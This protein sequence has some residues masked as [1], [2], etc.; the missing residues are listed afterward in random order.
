MFL[1]IRHGETIWNA[2]GRVQGHADSPLNAVGLEQA[3]LLA[4]KLAEHHPDIAAIYSSDLS[5]ALATAEKTAIKLR[6]PVVMREGLREI[7]C[8]VA[9]GI[10]F[11][12]RYALF[13][14]EEKEIYEKYATRKER[15]EYTAIPGAETLNQL[16]YRVQNELVAI[17]ALHPQQKIAIFTHGVVIRTI[18]E[19]CRDAEG[20]APLPNGVIVHISYSA[21]AG[22]QFLRIE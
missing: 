15:W 22:F 12:E 10:T 19:E 20:Y 4:D 16:L 7:C 18:V 5:R 6:L 2:E 17:E 8:G 13:G 1:L 14:A 21:D 3:T 9:E 11:A